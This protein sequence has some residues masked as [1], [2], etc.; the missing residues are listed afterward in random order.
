[1]WIAMAGRTIWHADAAGTGAQTIFTVRPR[2]RRV[3]QFRSLASA[4]EIDVL[5]FLSLQN[6]GPGDYEE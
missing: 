5:D 2:W 1:M 3:A 6:T 4:G